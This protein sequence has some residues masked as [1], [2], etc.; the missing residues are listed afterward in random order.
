MNTALRWANEI[1]P[2]PAL[3]PCLLDARERAKLVRDVNTEALAN[4]LFKGYQDQ[5]SVQEK[6]QCLSEV[7]E[8]SKIHLPTVADPA[9]RSNI[10]VRM[11]SGCLAA[12]RR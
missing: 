8:L 12:A 5:L 11:W 2:P 1:G 4:A 10:S 6:G 3:P 7:A 9:M